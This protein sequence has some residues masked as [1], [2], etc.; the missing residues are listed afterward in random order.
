MKLVLNNAEMEH[1]SLRLLL[2]PENE[3]ICSS[4]TSIDSP[5]CMDYI[6]EDGTLYYLCTLFP[7]TLAVAIILPALGQVGLCPR[8]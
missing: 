8:F 4:E 7:K 6:P 1:F 2:N 3:A 5:G